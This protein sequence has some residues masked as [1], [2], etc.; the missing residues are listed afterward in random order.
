MDKNKVKEPLRAKTA[1][2]MVEVRKNKE[3][4]KAHLVGVA[5]KYNERK[6]RKKQKRC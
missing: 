6:Q 4:V 2:R 1:E 3:R 5:R